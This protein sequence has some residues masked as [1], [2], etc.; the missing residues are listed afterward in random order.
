M[1]VY[2]GLKKCKRIIAG[3]DKQGLKV[4]K[5]CRDVDVISL[6]NGEGIRRPP[7]ATNIALVASAVGSS[8]DSF[9]KYS[10]LLRHNRLEDAIKKYTDH[11]HDLPIAIDMGS[12]RI[13]NNIFEYVLPKKSNIFIEV[14]FYH[15]FIGWAQAAQVNLCVTGESFQ[16]TTK[17]SL[18]SLEAGK[19]KYGVPEAVVIINP[20]YSGELYNQKELR[21]IADWCRE[22]NS[23]LIEDAVFQGTEYDGVTAKIL[24]VCDSIENVISVNSVSKSL[25]LSNLRLGWVMGCENIV[26]SLSYYSDL[27]T[28][29]I[30][31]LIA[32]IASEALLEHQDYK[33][34]CREQNSLRVNFL[35]KLIQ[36]ENLRLINRLGGSDDW[37]AIKTVP[38]S[39][40]NMFIHFP[41]LEAKFG[42]LKLVDSADLCEAIVNKSGVMLSP[43]LSSGYTDS[44]CRISFSGVSV[45][46]GYNISQKYE[47]KV[48]DCAL[49]KQPITISTYEQQLNNELSAVY[50][51]TLDIFEKAINQIAEAVIQM[52]EGENE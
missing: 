1:E 45:N 15:S 14:G 44:T 38:E 9:E 51:E 46:S 22:N 10:Y 21:D 27:A 16:H 12:T 17:T 8:K 24:D 2:E 41:A 18:K 52:V 33:E 43:S 40:Q 3:I 35:T 42:T 29:S 37:L 34:F 4:N 28:V 39:G 50:I 47:S 49:H 23:L 5:S 30:P 48:I 11:P 6:C 32:N 19:T 25:G 31:F 26:K 20:T 13:F 7:L 36:S